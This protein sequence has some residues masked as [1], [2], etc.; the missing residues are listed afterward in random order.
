MLNKISSNIISSLDRLLSVCQQKSNVPLGNLNSS[1]SSL[2]P[3]PQCD[4]Q[5]YLANTCYSEQ[6]V[7]MSHIGVLMGHNNKALVYKSSC[8]PCKMDKVRA[9]ALKSKIN[10]SE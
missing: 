4:C 8:H 5:E 2:F 1:Y 3:H 10:V 6:D 9:K 7:F